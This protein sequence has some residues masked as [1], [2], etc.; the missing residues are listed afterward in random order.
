MEDYLIEL[1]SQYLEEYVSLY[2]IDEDDERR[3]YVYAYIDIDMDDVFYIGKGTAYRINKMYHHNKNCRNYAN[4]H[5]YKSFIILDYLSEQQAYY[6]ENK[7]V[8]HFINE[9][10]YGI[11]IDGYRNPF[12]IHHLYTQQF[13]GEGYVT[14]FKT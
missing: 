2:G 6:I 3:Y 1:A 9:C 12:S 7:L 13:G 8:A 10:D 14:K 5:N 4:T 11:D